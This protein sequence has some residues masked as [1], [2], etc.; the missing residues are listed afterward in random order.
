M[1][2]GIHDVNTA[3]GIILGST[4]L[5]SL[6]DGAAVESGREDLSRIESAVRLG[7]IILQNLFLLGEARGAWPRE[8]SSLHAL[9][10]EGLEQSRGEI[11]SKGLQVDLDLSAPRDEAAVNPRLLRQAFINIL[12]AAVAATPA[13]GKIR[14]STRLDA[15]GGRRW[16]EA[17]MEDGGPRMDG[18]G[19]RRYFDPRWAALGRGK[20]VGLGLYLSREILLRHGAGVELRPMENAGNKVVVRFPLE[21]SDGAPVRLGGLEEAVS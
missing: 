16:L 12:F 3:L 14:I 17:A 1:A 7:K 21:E 4:Q 5:I 10:E 9:L 2:L 20:G 15:G 11:R 13:G 6:Q 8:K 18:E 19:V